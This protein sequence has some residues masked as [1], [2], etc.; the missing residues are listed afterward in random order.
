MT[1]G[2]TPELQRDF[3]ARAKLVQQAIKEMHHTWQLELSSIAIGIPRRLDID[4]ET[5]A[6]HD[7]IDQ[8][9]EDLKATTK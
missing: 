6:C 4:G 8:L 7:I 9:A 2:T 5:A 3:D 1:L